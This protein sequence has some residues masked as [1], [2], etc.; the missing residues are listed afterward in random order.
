MGELSAFQDALNSAIGDDDEAIEPWLVNGLAHTPGLAVYRNTVA[1][2]VIDALVAVYSTV[3]RMVGEEWFRAAAKLYA[4]EH[5]PTAPSLLHYGADFPDWLARFPPAEDTPYLSA[6]ARL[7]RLWWDSYFAA[8][9]DALDAQAIARLQAADLDVAILRLNPS[10][11]LAAF[12]QNL[13]SLWLAHR[14]PD[15]EPGAFEI[16]E[17]AERILIVRDGLVVQA[18]LIDRA[19]YA[20]LSACAGGNSLLAAASSAGAAD[21]EAS[22]PSIIGANLE[23]GVFSRLDGARR[24][25]CLDR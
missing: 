22:L 7:D 4:G 10:V 3:V 14:Q 2:G 13:A 17:P 24:E 16:G 18:R 11:R 8:D 23:A 25:L 12:D 5:P 19:S 9:G 20:F 6:V 1:R 21:P 15:L